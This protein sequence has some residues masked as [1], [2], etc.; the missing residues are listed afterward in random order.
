MIDLIKLVDRLSGANLITDR[1]GIFERVYIDH[2]ANDSRK[3]GPSG[4]FV[5][6]KG[7][8]ADGHLFI[9]KAVQNGAIAIVCEA[10]PAEVP[11]HF[12]GIV[13]VQVTNAR[14]ALA[15]LA[16]AF[17]GDPAKSLRM[18][19]VTG[20][21]GKTT[22]AFLV[23]HM[24]GEL[25]VK[26][27]L[28]STVEYKIGDRTKEATHTTP[29]ILDTSQLLKEMVDAGCTACVM[30]VSSHALV[31]DRVRTI[32]FEVAVFTNLTQDHL[33]YHGT[34]ENYLAAKK[35]L[36]DT[37]GQD[38]KA[39]YNVDDA[40]GEALVADTPAR[41]LS[42]GHD[43]TALLHATVVENTLQGLLLEIEGVAYR[44]KLV[45][46][47]NAYNLLAA[48]GVGVA[49]GFESNTVLAALASANPVP[50]RFEILSVSD[51]RF[52]IVDYAH[53]PDALE[54]VL[55]TLA[56]TKAETA[57]MWCVFGCGGD[58]DAK[59][60]PMMGRIAEELADEIVVTSDNP[61]TE[62]PETILN[63]IRAGFTAPEKA[64]WIVNRKEAIQY[65]AQ[66]AA[67][68]DVVLIA[69]KGHE[70]YQVIGTTKYDFDD[71]VEA[72]KAFDFWHSKF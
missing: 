30:E 40:A 32:P 45:G 59:K 41:V 55:Q 33:D 61:R 7:G 71:R 57:K 42:Y 15:E 5:A 3:V 64:A 39:V 10:M 19:G 52:V 6:I 21:N 38:A 28:I 8:L 14:T 16:A 18:I 46:Q 13:F 43:G 34:M 31:Q 35:I 1:I 29:D 20:T 11:T 47:F 70:P 17:Y 60:R 63:D 48:Y 36:F 23:H 37:L 24:L 69:G 9:E 65:V 66:H 12:P 50:G 67:S 27:G 22:T 54:N 4:L 44:F 51:A 72:G 62:D 68:G 53:T 56:K 49:M 2:L 26:A 58:R 25:E